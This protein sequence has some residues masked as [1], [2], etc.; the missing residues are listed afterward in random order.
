MPPVSTSPGQRTNPTPA[1]IFGGAIT[2]AYIASFPILFAQHLWILDAKGRPLVVDFIE[3]WVAGRLALSG[4]AATPYDPVAHHAA[5]VAAIGY[6][7]PGFLGWHYPPLYLFVA[8]AIGALPYLAAFLVWCAVT[9][10]MYAY[11]IKL[12]T[13]RTDAVLIALA[14]PASFGC[15]FVGQNGFLLAALIGAALLALEDMPILGGVLIG[16][17]ACK[18]QLG[19][20]FPIVLAASGRWRAFAAAA[21]SVVA[22]IL[23]SWAAFGAATFHAFLH[24]LPLTEHFVLGQGS[25]G[26]NKLQ[27]IYGAARWLGAGDHTAWLAQGAMTLACIVTMIWLWRRDVPYALKAAGLV[28][29]ITLATPYLYMY[30]FPILTVAAAFLWRDG[31]LDRIE[32]GGLILAALLFMVYVCVTMPIGPAILLLMGGLVLRRTGMLRRSTA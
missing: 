7:F 22:G 27:S 12:I 15:V 14:S 8:A 10:G 13:R 1:F 21:V 4:H 17:I 11:V 25:A 31:A 26:W 32:W 30:D 16:L 6:G 23:I 19:I 18:P 20:L 5:Q 29:A 24:F 9:A 3:V 28:V 2:L